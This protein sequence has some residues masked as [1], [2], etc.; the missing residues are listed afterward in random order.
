MAFTVLVFDW[1]QHGGR[2]HGD[3]GQGDG[4]LGDGGHNLVEVEQDRVRLRD[5]IQFW[6][7]KYESEYKCKFSL[8]QEF[9]LST[10]SLIR[11]SNALRATIY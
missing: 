7:S 2:G 5:E 11:P 3:G 4:G 10:S 6:R 8:M 9:Y 1:L